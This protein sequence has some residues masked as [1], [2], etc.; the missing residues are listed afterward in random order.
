MFARFYPPRARSL[1]RPLAWL[2]VLLIL[3]HSNLAQSPGVLPR[4]AVWF[5][6]G[7]GE[8]NALQSW[9]GKAEPAAGPGDRHSVMLESTSSASGA[10]ISR[11]LPVEQ[12][13]GCVI[14]GSVTVKAQDV[15]AKPNAWN[16]I[17]CMLV[18]EGSGGRQYPQA[19]LEV[20]SFDWRTAG[21]T[22]RVPAD[23]TNATLVLGMELVT[24][25]VWFD[26]VKL[27]VV[28]SS[29]TAS[30]RPVPGHMYKGHDQPRL[31][32]AMISPGI[33]AESLRVF[34]QDWKA[35]LI[36]WQLIRT[37][38]QSRD[39]SDSGYDEWL[40]AELKKLDAALPL[41]EKYGIR[42]VLDLHSPPG[43][44]A[45]AG[46]YAGSDNGFFTDPKSQAKFFQIWQ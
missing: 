15:S 18:V 37:G 6:T 17:K 5:Q 3:P 16:G 10:V 32:G 23:A 46:G 40:E 24:G 2:V 30:P 29:A 41:C 35:N 1:Y 7:F 8:S 25:K 9:S 31:R 33:D 21:F 45:T 27:S 14:R 19:P 11:H 36:R 28:R 43:G 38:Q 34:G 26:D 20:G 22:T 4:G 39:A 44:K 42:V 12:V 13:R